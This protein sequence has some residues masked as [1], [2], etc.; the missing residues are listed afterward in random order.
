M[1]VEMQMTERDKKLL[2]F[3]A[4]FVIVVGIGY[5]GI[6]P[7]IMDV[8]D[9]KDHIVEADDTWTLNQMKIAEIPVLEADND[10][11][12]EEIKEAR[13]HFYPMMKSDQIDKLMTGMVLSYNL[14]SYDLSIKMPTAEA[15]STAYKYSE[16]YL[17]DIA[18]AEARELEAL[19]EEEEK[20]AESKSK[21]KTKTKSKSKYDDLDA[22]MEMPELDISFEDLATGV[23]AVDISMRLGGDEEDIQRFIDNL[24]VT[25]QELMIKSYEW[26]SNQ[27][28]R[29]DEEAQDYVMDT[30]RILNINLV[31]YMCEE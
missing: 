20:E 26:T 6:R 14:Y 8:I 23:Y 24:S 9:I 1:K 10:V 12:E 18:E 28:M 16:K 19:Q 31:L 2:I 22:A 15:S 5:W 29:F 13:Q 11:Y 17:S 30:S 21:S 7:L 4:V 27:Q 3:L 25:D